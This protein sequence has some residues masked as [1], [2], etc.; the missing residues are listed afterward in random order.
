MILAFGLNTSSTLTTSPEPFLATLRDVS[1]ELAVD[2]ICWTGW[3]GSVGPFG[4][5]SGRTCSPAPPCLMPVL[6]AHFATGLGKLG[7]VIWGFAPSALHP[8]P[9]P[10]PPTTVNLTSRPRAFVGSES[11]EAVVDE[12]GRLHVPDEASRCW[13]VAP[14]GDKGGWLDV[15]Q[16]MTGELLGL[17]G[18]SSQSRL[19]S[20]ETRLPADP[21]LN[22]RCCRLSLELA[23]DPSSVVRAASILALHDKIPARREV[24]TATPNFCRVVAGASHALLVPSAP[25]LHP[26]HAVGSNLH[27]QLAQPLSATLVE[28]PVAIEL[29][30][31]LGQLEVRAAGVY[32]LALTE[33]GEVYVWGGRFG[34][35]DEALD[36]SALSGPG[37]GESVEPPH[38]IAASVGS[39]GAIMLG[40]SDG[41]VVAT[42]VE[43]DELVP[44]Q[45]VDGVSA[46]STS[47]TDDGC[48]QWK[49]LRGKDRGRRLRVI[50]VASGGRGWFLVFD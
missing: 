36:L 49:V 23:N 22:A 34:L 33:A 31:G 2:T 47:R 42:G 25:H 44:T 27:S 26:P 11:L 46:R 28:D 18:T 30:E 32:S 37:E 39:T 43:E 5:P 12:A 41:R 20:F 9:C 10:L 19:T 4:R 1:S 50:V 6:L 14:G 40:L 29:L 15:Q 48:L 16:L 3:G 24:S 38:V 13:L 8:D 35:P 7:H 45:P 21:P 17:H